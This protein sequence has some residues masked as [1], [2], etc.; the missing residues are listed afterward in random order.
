VAQI[1]VDDTVQEVEMMTFVETMPEFDGGV[2]ELVQFIAD[3]LNYPRK[4]QK[5]NIEGMVIVSF[6]VR[7]TGKI[8]DIEVIKDIGKGCGKEA[9]RVVALTEGKWTPGQQRG[10]PVNVQYNLPVRFKLTE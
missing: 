9:A 1:E 10:K 8:T 3:N 4:A 2:N 5:K 7:K 6:V